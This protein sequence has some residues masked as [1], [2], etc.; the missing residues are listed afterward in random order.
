VLPKLCAILN[1]TSTNPNEP[2]CHL[3]PI[4]AWADRVRRLPQYRW[5][6]SLHYV[7]GKDDYPSETC[8]FPGNSGWVNGPVNL[9]NGIVNT[10]RIL[11][12]WDG[13]AEEVGSVTNEALKFLVHFY[14]DLHMPLHT[15][16]RARGG[17]GIKVTFD[18]RHT[19]LHSLWDG[20]LIAQRLRTLPSNYTLPLLIPEIEFNLRGAIYDP[21][22]RRVMWE[23]IM[24]RWKGEVQQWLSCP[25]PEPAFPAAGNG[26][27]LQT[28]MGMFRRSR[29][30]AGE[31]D[32]DLICPYAWAKPINAMN[33][34]FIFPKAL[35]EHPY[36]AR[37]HDADHFGHDMCSK[38]EHEDEA[39]ADGA[40][41]L[42]LDTPE[43][44]GRIRDEFVI[45][46]LIA[47]GGIRLAGVL[48][49][50][51]ADEGA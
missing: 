8:A 9:L 50:L 20:L 49:F 16:G 39:H 36:R 47:Q 34:D 35:D 2:E 12:E 37:Y 15:A 1:W 51:F 25:S 23:G 43:Y 5:T 3:A 7:E 46:K 41:Y 4:A 24:G 32:D 38:T 13:R 40:P 28:V 10:T 44:A 48:N 31:T 42:E 18:G 27:M 19:N 30:V 22:V 26:G 11:E 17:N 21:Y 45:E 29:N 6:G 14:G 33:C